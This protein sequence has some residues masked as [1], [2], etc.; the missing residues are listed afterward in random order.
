MLYVYI[1]VIVVL[2]LA[3]LLYCFFSHCFMKKVL[4]IKGKTKLRGKFKL[5]KLFE[6]DFEAEHNNK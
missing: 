2:I 6:F 4:L 5:F 3:I 1:F